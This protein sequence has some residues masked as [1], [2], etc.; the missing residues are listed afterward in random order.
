MPAVSNSACP[1]SAGSSTGQ[2]PGHDSEVLLKPVRIFP[3]PFRGMYIVFV[4]HTDPWCAPFR[5]VCVCTLLCGP[6]S[7]TI[8]NPAYTPPHTLQAHPTSWCCASA[9]PPTWSPSP[10]TPA[11]TPTCFSPASWRRSLGSAWSRSTP[12]STRTRGR[13]WAG[14][15]EDTP[16]PRDH[17]TALWVQTTPS[18]G[19]WWR[20]TTRHACT[21]ASRSVVSTVRAAPHRAPAHR[22][23]RA[24]S[25]QRS[26]SRLRCAQL[27]R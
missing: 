12:C 17:T 11:A 24:P 7:L 26:V 19:W 6:P 10:P 18:A 15:R 21:P 22:P 14:P 8:R 20:P 25:S 1:L 16:A 5:C 23:T 3:D 2:A 27:C 9:S 13:P 4:S